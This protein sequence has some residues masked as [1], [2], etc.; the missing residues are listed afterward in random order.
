MAQAISLNKVEYFIVL[1]L[2]LPISIVFLQSLSTRAITEVNFQKPYGIIN[3]ILQSKI[4]NLFYIQILNIY[5]IQ[6]ITH[7]CKSRGT[8]NVRTRE[9]GSGEILVDW[10]KFLMNTLK[11]SR[12]F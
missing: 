7:V 11:T 10:G 1:K 9:R 5:Y 12:K 2:D 3:F 6:I 8:E 4:L